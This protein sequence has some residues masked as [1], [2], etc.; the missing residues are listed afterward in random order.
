[1]KEGRKTKAERREA[2]EDAQSR[3]RTEQKRVREWKSKEFPQDTT[4]QMSRRMQINPTTRRSKLCTYARMR[5]SL[6]QGFAARAGGTTLATNT[7]PTNAPLGYVTATVQR[8]NET[9]IAAER[10]L[11]RP[12][13]PTRPGEP[14]PPARSSSGNNVSPTLPVVTRLRLLADPL[15]ANHG[16]PLAYSTTF[17][18]RCNTC[19]TA[20]GN[21]Q[22]ALYMAP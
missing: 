7:Q 22:T 12:T 2:E 5:Q 10:A 11:S 18:K 19:Q 9:D 21:H 8:R 16:S 1:M 6:F 3:K 20:G 14:P 13:C 4:Q 15:G 17:L